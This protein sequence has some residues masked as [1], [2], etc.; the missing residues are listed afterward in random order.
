MSHEASQGYPS[1]HEGSGETRQGRSS[2]T[3]LLLSGTIEA[4]GIK[5]PVRIRNLSETGALLEG[6]A[7]PAVGDPLVLR[8]LQMEMAARVV[9]SENGRCGIS[10]DGTISVAGWREG[11]WIAP[12]VSSDQ[13]RADSIQAAARAG[14]L[15]ES[16][17]EK[18]ARDRVTRRALD[19]R[20]AAELVAIRD[21]L[22]NMGSQ[23]SEVPAVVEGHPTTLQNFDLACQT[24]AHLATLLRAEDAR[25][26]LGTVGMQDLRH[27]LSQD[28][29]PND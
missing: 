20:I 28:A 8:R 5:A 7:L 16:D 14:T 17:A 9:W 11:N 22:E 13:A 4:P 21:M 15:A 19:R 1:L 3:N 29:P 23:L 10:F 27:R 2:R 26:A 6:A 12:V 25:A 18:Q 24:L